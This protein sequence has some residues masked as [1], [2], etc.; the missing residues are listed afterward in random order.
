M[1]ASR[2]R[3][4]T[5]MS[6]VTPQ[7]RGM[8]EAVNSAMGTLQRAY[9]RKKGYKSKYFEKGSKFPEAK[10][11]TTIVNQTIVDSTA[12]S[13]FLLN[14][15]AQGIGFNQRIGQK[16]R[17]TSF[18]IHLV[19]GNPIADTTAFQAANNQPIVVRIALVSDHDAGQTLAPIGDIWETNAINVDTMALRN[20]QFIERYAVLMDRTFVLDA[21]EANSFNLEHYMKLGLETHYSGTTAAIGSIASGSLALYLWS[22]VTGI[23]GLAPVVEGFVRVKYTD[24]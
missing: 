24:D 6:F 11:L 7:R 22:N 19:G 13:T 20:Q 2:K 21:C 17:V 23:S 14:G 3:A 5:E 18:Q 10:Y 4:R 12:V 8:A 15:C 1:S 9:R 16:I